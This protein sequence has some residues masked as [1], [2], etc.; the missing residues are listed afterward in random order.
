MSRYSFPGMGPPVAIVAI[1]LAVAACG[2]A[3]DPAPTQTRAAELAKLTAV[4]VATPSPNALAT[5]TRAAE[6]GQLATLTAPP[7]PATALTSAGSFVGRIANSTA[8]IGIVSD[9]ARVMAY[10]CDGT[11]VAQ[12]F[13]GSVQGD[14]LE[15]GAPDGARLTAEFSAT[16]DAGARTVRSAAGA[17]RTATGQVLDFTAAVTSGADRA[18]LYRATGAVDGGNFVMGVIVLPDGSSRGAIRRGQMLDPVSNP[19]FD[20]NTL[21]ASVPAVGTFTAPRLTVP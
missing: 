18:G 6:L 20:G 4:A 16:S 14:R 13:S 19:T 9:G 15:L 21:T 10:V 2:P 11:T 12:W 7:A 17:F 5:Q 3:A 8:F 1:A